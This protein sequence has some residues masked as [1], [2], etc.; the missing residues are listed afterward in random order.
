MP[1]IWTS[2]QRV[3]AALAHQQPDRMPL[4]MTI[5]EIP[6]VR[7]CASTWA[8]RRTMKVCAPTALAKYGP[9]DD[10]LQE[11][12]LDMTFIKLRGPANWSPP[13]PDVDGTDLR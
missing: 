9:A 10:L 13:P 3:E 1:E 6:Y 11:L 2:R 4:D 8:C 5:T 7:P 12:G